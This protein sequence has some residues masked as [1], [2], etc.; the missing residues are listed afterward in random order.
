MDDVHVTNTGAVSKD[1]KPQKQSR[2]SKDAEVP[3]SFPPLPVTVTITA[4]QHDVSPGTIRMLRSSQSCAEHNHAQP[5]CTLSPGACTNLTATN[6]WLRLGHGV[7]L[8]KI[9]LNNNIKIEKWPIVPMG[10]MS[11]GL[12]MQEYNICSVINNPLAFS[13]LKHNYY[14]FQYL[15][16][17]KQNKSSS[18]HLQPNS[19]AHFCKR[20]SI[21]PP[22]VWLIALHFYFAFVKD[23]KCTLCFP[24]EFRCHNA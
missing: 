5:T 2:A 3:P 13:Q 6:S 15:K 9:P 11:L 14:N 19:R 17:K 24:T 4:A 20:W 1:R 18:V 23:I 7:E 10:H 21:L 22:A 16:K 12:H 8:I